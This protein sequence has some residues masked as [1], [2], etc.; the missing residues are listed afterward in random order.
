MHSQSEA[1]IPSEIQAILDSVSTPVFTKKSLNV[2][3][4]ERERIEED[5]REQAVTA[6]VSSQSSMWENTL[7]KGDNRS[8]INIGPVSKALRSTSCSYQVGCRQ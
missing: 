8:F 4:E 5:T 1:V 6:V 7:S 2:G 3:R